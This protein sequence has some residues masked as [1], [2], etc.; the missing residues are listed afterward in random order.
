[1][2]AAK[3]KEHA[4]FQVRCY[5]A[6]YIPR[7]SEQ[8]FAVSDIYGD[9]LRRDAGESTRIF[10]D[11]LGDEEDAAQW[12][13]QTDFRYIA[14]ACVFVYLGER[15]YFGSEAIRAGRLAPAWSSAICGFTLA[16]RTSYQNCVM[17][18][19]K[20][21]DPKGAARFPKF[22]WREVVGDWETYKPLLFP[23]CT[24]ITHRAQN[25]NSIAEAQSVD[26]LV[27]NEQFVTWLRWR[28]VAEGQQ[29][30]AAFRLLWG[31][32]YLSIVFRYDTPPTVEYW[33]NGQWQ[34]WKTLSS[35]PGSTFDPNTVTRVS[36]LRIAGRLVVGIDNEFY[37][38]LG[39]R[40]ATASGSA[41]NGVFD[42]ADVS[43]NAGPLRVRSFGVSVMVGIARLR[44]SAPADRADG[45]TP[46]SNTVTNKAEPLAA[47][48][49]LLEREVSRPHLNTPGGG[50]GAPGDGSASVGDG[51]AG[52]WLK[53]GTRATITTS[54]TP[55]KVRYQ[56][57]MFASPDGVSAPFVNK[58]IARYL[59]FYVV[60]NA[61]FL[62][63]QR[64]CLTARETCAFPPLA[65]GA[66]WS[67]EVDRSV[68]DLLRPDWKTWVSQY[69][70]IEIMMRWKY[71]DGTRSEWIGRLHGYISQVSMACNQANK[72]TMTL[73][74]KDP[75]WRLQG[76]NGRVDHNFYPLD[77]LFARMGGAPLYG[78]QCVQELLKIALGEEQAARFLKY[79]PPFHYALLSA[80]T[81]HGGYF[82][83]TQPPHTNGFRFPAPFGQDVLSWIKQ[84]CKYDYAQFFY[85]HAN[86]ALAGT[87]QI[88]GASIP[89]AGTTAATPWPVPIYGQYPQIIKGRPTWLVPDAEY[90]PGDTNLLAFMAEVT[91]LPEENINRVLVWGNPPQG[92]A[93]DL[94]FPAIRRAER[95]LQDDDPNSALFS[96]ARTLI[97]QGPQFFY[98]GAAEIHA[99]RVMALYRNK[100]IR[101]FRF[102]CRGEERMQWGDLAM[103]FMPGT[104]AG[105]NYS[106]PHMDVHGERFRIWRMVNNINFAARDM[107][108]YKSNATCLPIS[109]LGY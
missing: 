64:A 30:P 83:N 11:G 43:W 101:R 107:S 86:G 81:D 52:G 66:D 54:I 45:G 71:S 56:L 12:R 109:A 53:G 2:A 72:W 85:G 78:W 46:G 44:H 15:V 57:K 65:P 59:G 69:N 51:V 106:D 18:P 55:G 93:A 42:L 92:A 89:L 26:P 108:Q 91:G 7:L 13:K 80:T 61:P 39:A 97:H 19:G 70:P 37:E 6:E 96:W 1:M 22:R 105:G 9:L 31:N 38:L 32:E 33:E 21:K 16:M 68:L 5:S 10:A 102:E 50:D 103:P 95:T 4:E 67:I 99:E 88:A 14:P 25:P 48:S 74:A 98:P 94:P 100:K 90:A 84:F 23:G 73:G 75:I 24:Y 79:L 41:A 82:P 28:G 36:V 27:A 76:N 20:S 87:T 47:L 3:I 40:R 60:T 63:I 49:G 62:D 8:H 29:K 77:F 17:A 34:N 35:S 104:G 58:V